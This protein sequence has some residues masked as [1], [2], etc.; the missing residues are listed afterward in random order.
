MSCTA[1]AFSVSSYYLNYAL[2]SSSTQLWF[3]WLGWHN[4]GHVEMCNG[5]SHEQRHSLY[6]P[7]I[8]D[9]CGSPRAAETTGKY[10]YLLH[11][12]RGSAP[13]NLIHVAQTERVVKD[14][15]LKRWIAPLISNHFVFWRFHA[16]F[17]KPSSSSTLPH[18]NHNYLSLTKVREFR[19]IGFR[20]IGHHVVFVSNTV[21]DHI[22]GP[23][24]P[25]VQAQ[26]RGN[27][28]QDAVL[29]SN[30]DIE[31]VCFPSY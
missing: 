28:P 31:W 27:L 25:T 23:D 14:E 10:L 22:S 18:A 17:W 20:F 12:W 4:L 30:G 9:V 19:S 16:N 26:V 5:A 7:N 13:T 15:G 24:A 2:L 11:G 1:V 21:V 3:V 29:H 8:G 6:L